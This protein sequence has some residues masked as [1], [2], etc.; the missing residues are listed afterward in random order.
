[1][2]QTNDTIGDRLNTPGQ[3]VEIRVASARGSEDSGVFGSGMR[4]V[5]RIWSFRWSQT[6]PPAPVARQRRQKN[7]DS[8]EKS[9]ADVTAMLISGTGTNIIHPCVIGVMGVKELESCNMEL[10]DGKRQ[11]TSAAH[12]DR[13]DQVFVRR[14][15][16]PKPSSVSPAS[17]RPS[18]CQDFHVLPLLP[19]SIH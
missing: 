2:S 15:S 6:C 9:G 1:M 19:S 7:T 5:K 11:P 14:P 13:V 10:S 16:G 18:T 8:S 3:H 17:V 4:V 12:F